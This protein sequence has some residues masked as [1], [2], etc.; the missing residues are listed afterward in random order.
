MFGYILISNKKAWFIVFT[1]MLLDIYNIYGQVFPLKNTAFNT[2]ITGQ[3][4]SIKNIHSGANQKYLDSLF[5][6]KDQVQELIKTK[7]SQFIVTRGT[8]MVYKQKSENDSLIAFER[9]DSTQFDGYN[10]DDIKFE[11]NDTLFSIG[12]FGF[13][14]N[15][16]QVRYFTENKEW[17]LLF[18][19]LPLGIS[20]RNLWNL[21]QEKGL[22]FAIVKANE[23]DYKLVKID[24]KKKNWNFEPLP[25]IIH[26][27]LLL[28]NENPIQIQLNNKTG[29]LLCFSNKLYYLDLEKSLLKE[30][31]NNKLLNFINKQKINEASY[32]ENSGMLYVF[33]LNTFIIDSIYFNDNDFS[34]LSQNAYQ[35]GDYKFIT[36]L[37]AI[38]LIIGIVVFYVSSRKKKSSLEMNEFEK[39]FIKK[40]TNKKGAVIDINNLNYLLGLSKKSIEIQKKNRSEFLNK[41]NQKLKEVLNTQEN[42]IIRIKD[43]EDKRVFI[44][45]L[46]EAYFEKIEEKI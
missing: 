36:I 44:Y 35:L 22:L 41:L 46:D 40:L 17:E 19:E 29:S 13:W 7:K 24:L 11:Y 14:R 25:S 16:G 18:S 28:M 9:I 30:A 31:S 39:E 33:N 43:E 42:V 45:K 1:I 38:L 26:S 3:I 8:G 15:N 34:V 12:G 27:E 37:L 23:A 5:L 10:F 4:G 21:N 6:K 20:N 2:I 32:F